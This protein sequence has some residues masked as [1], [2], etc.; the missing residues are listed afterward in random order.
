MLAGCPPLPAE[1]IALADARGCVLAEA[2]VAA[3]AI[4][5]FANSAM[6]GFAVHAADV[7]GASVDAPAVLTVVATIK[8]GDAGDVALGPGEAIRIMT[9]APVPAG[10]DSVVMV[11]RT[12]V[13]DDGATVEVLEAVEAG[14]SVR[15]AGDDIAIGQQ[16][17]AVGDVITPGHIGVLASL[18]FTEVRAH[19]RPRVGVFSTGDELVEGGLPLGPGQI[20]DSN[21]I[22]LLALVAESGFDGVDLGCLPDDEAVIAEALERAGRECDAVITTGGVSMGD[23]DFVKVVLDRIGEMRW[24]QIAIKPSKPLAFGTIAGGPDEAPAAPRVPVFGLPG[25]PVSSTVSY[26]LFARP[27]LRQ[28]M[29]HAP[30]ALDRPRVLAVADGPLRRR[31]DGKTHF[32]RVVTRYEDGVH[33]VTSA[34]GQGSHQLSA[35]AFADGL[36]VLPD[37]DGVEPGATVEVIVL[38]G[39]RR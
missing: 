6:D 27:A 11:E 38:D 9:G 21:R 30:S 2:V 28:M 19:R 20:R 10:A 14:T 4:P 15:P 13:A 39:A 37:G 7:A 12:V 31:P 29:G 33:R 35:M 34:G 36:A 18:G 17:F 3:E 26:E 5:P 23:Y 22:T 16:V 25:N 32:A 8:A 24:M 1:T